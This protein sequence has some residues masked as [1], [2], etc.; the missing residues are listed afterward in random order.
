MP[1]IRYDAFISYRHK[2]LDAAVAR[3]LHR[4]LETYR[5]PAYIRQKT[6]KRKMGKLFRDRDEL[7]LMADLG[8]GIRQALEQSDWLIVVCTPDLPLSKWC[9]AEIDY[10]IEMGRRERILTVLASGEPEESF[11]EQ[12]RFVSEGGVT[13]EREPLAADV[14]AG[15]LSGTLKKIRREKL[16]LL[17][18]MLGVGY[19]DLRRRQRERRMRV[20]A[21]V[22]AAAAA[23]SIGAAAYVLRQNQRL[24]EQR[25]IAQENAQWAVQE[26]NGALVSQSK[27]L[28]GLSHERLEA[29][30]PVM[31]ALLALEALPES[32]STPDRPLVDE[33]VSALRTAAASRHEMDFM[34]TSGVQTLY[35]QGYEYFENEDILMVS[36]ARTTELFSG[37]TGMPVATLPAGQ[38]AYC[39]QRSLLA[40]NGA[41][42]SLDGFAHVAG[43]EQEF[44]GSNQA[45]TPDGAYFVA[46]RVRALFENQV[47]VFDPQTG[48][49]V[50]RLTDA[51]LFSPQEA[52]SQDAGLYSLAFSPDGRYMA[53]SIFRA[54]EGA[55]AIRILDM[56]SFEVV[57]ELGDASWYAALLFSPDGTQLCVRGEGD[58]FAE[59]WDVESGERLYRFYEHEGDGGYPYN[60]TAHYSPDGRVLLWRTYDDRLWLF[61]AK[62]GEEL[63]D[64]L[65]GE[66]A[67][68]FSFTADGKLAVRVGDDSSLIRFYD[69]ETGDIYSMTL[70]GLRKDPLSAGLHDFPA[71]KL[72][73]DCV[74]AYADSG[75]YQ[76]WKRRQNSD[77]TP[78]VR[79]TDRERRQ[80]AFSR[81]GERFAVETPQGLMLFTKDGA[82]HGALVCEQGHTYAHS[83]VFWSPDDSQLL[84]AGAD[85]HVCL[86]D[87][88]SGKRLLYLESEYTSSP[89]EPQV[90][91]SPDWSRFAID[92]SSH[93]AG[94][95]TLPGGE[96]AYDFE[97]LGGEVMKL[98][99]DACFT[100]DGTRLLVD[101]LGEI[102]V[103]DAATGKKLGAYPYHVDNF[104]QLSPDGTK[105]AFHPKDE[106]GNTLT[107]IDPDTGEKLW[108][109]DG[110][111]EVYRKPIVWS[112][113]S[114]YVATSESDTALTKVWDAETG[115]LVQTLEIHRIDFS[116]DGQWVC[117]EAATRGTANVYSDRGAGR[118]Y[119][120]SDGL[121]IANLPEAGAFSPDG[122]HV[123]MQSYLWTVKPPEQ[124]M[125]EALA[126]LSGRKLTAEERKRF[127]LD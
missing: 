33:A 40:I 80:K 96:F 49:E 29:G 85:G 102:A 24:D 48:E 76:I 117:G 90:A 107:V 94:V 66:T 25:R 93:V 100:A 77:I 92:G 73:G 3:Q 57:H 45:F 64:P 60:N 61:D 42:Y 98:Y 88:A 62:T 101:A 109:V 120:L 74:V 65:E 126:R 23:V 118:V 121:L 39:P 34:L 106:E 58:D 122:G 43:G 116:P 127:F 81:D 10:F 83:S 16:R 125:E 110:H 27:F 91:V 71:L 97:H 13:V 32:S 51:D 105:L 72:Y 37:S 17:A 119:R 19:D 7:P 79:H 82:P 22:S 50:F 36:R 124:M 11:P 75:V 111:E 115:K 84:C 14:R 87:A 108:S 69:L 52:G 86:W 44:L 78:L 95:Y 103:L 12:L 41:F 8:E 20:V 63:P 31:A 56:R 15:T 4:Q 89:F 1:E 5:I 53:Y 68:W 55:R 67:A 47:T 54:P 26:K 114:R 59:V 46:W 104:L 9:V 21:G 38:A 113:D 28:A 99:G 35:D 2:D 112:P 18:P 123:L 70:S 6:G 30:D